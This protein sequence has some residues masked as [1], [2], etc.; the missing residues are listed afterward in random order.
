MQGAARQGRPVFSLTW[1]EK[2][3]YAVKFS[4]SVSSLQAFFICVAI[5]SSQNLPSLSEESSRM[6]AKVFKEPSLGGNEK[7]EVASILTQGATR[8]IPNPPHSLVER[9]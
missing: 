4:S 2:G 5:L 8:Y 6:E 9:V 1:F 7:I 3:I